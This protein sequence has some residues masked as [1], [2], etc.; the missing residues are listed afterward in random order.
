MYMSLYHVHVVPVVARRGAISSGTGV[1]SGGNVV[2]VG[3]NNQNQVLYKS[4]VL[5]SY[6]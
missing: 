2:T 1:I 3:A 4:T 5:N 6:L